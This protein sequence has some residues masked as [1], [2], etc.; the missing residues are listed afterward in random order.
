MP[1]FEK[2]I[3]LLSGNNPES[4]GAIIIDVRVDEFINAC[5][6]EEY[7]DLVERIRVIENKTT[8]QTSPQGMRVLTPEEIDKLG[9]PPIIKE[10]IDET[11][12]P[13]RRTKKK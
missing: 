13:I 7:I 4:I 8:Q 5:S 2:E 11:R 1:Q 9:L 10:P 3:T 12:K 6:D